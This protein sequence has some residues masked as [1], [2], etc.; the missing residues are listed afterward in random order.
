MGDVVTLP[1]STFNISRPRHNGSHFPD[2][3]FKCIFV[4]ENISISINI[5]LKFVPKSSI[6]NIPASVQIMARR[7]PGHKPLSESMM[8]NLLTHIFVT[9][10]QWL[11]GC[12]QTAF[13]VR[14]WISNCIPH[15]NKNTLETCKNPRPT[16]GWS[17]LTKSSTTS[18]MNFHMAYFSWIPQNNAKFKLSCKFGESKCNPC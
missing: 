10:T 1:C 17:E 4:N 8:V 7:R 6:N 5:S 11:K 15:M 18:T 12:S 16:S 3:I 13:E 2:D 9:R 14:A